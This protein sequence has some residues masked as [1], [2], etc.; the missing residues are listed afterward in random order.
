M[1]GNIIS[2]SASIHEAA[3]QGAKLIA[4]P[5]MTSLM[6]MRKGAL[7]G[8]AVPE[9]DDPAL[10]AFRELAAELKVHL[11]I[12]SLPVRL[13]EQ[14]CANRSFLIAPT[15]A[16]A[17]RYD[18]IHMF[19]VA[20]ND[21][22]DYRESAKFEP[23]REAIVAD[24]GPLSLGLSVCYDLRFPHLYRMLAQAG[25]NVLCVPAAFTR[26]TGQAHW[27][28]LL[29]ARAIENGAYV[30]APAQGGHHADGRETYGH[31]LVVAPWGE[32]IAEL[33]TEPGVLIADLDLALVAEARRKIPALTHDRPIAPARQP[34]L[35]S[36]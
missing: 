17:A 20:V 24:A 3:E 21:G 9:A 2:A 34:A 6:D 31:S 15:G 1:V 13:S 30:L 35:K 26:V 11:L 28:V 22:Q 32:I 14:K 23:G 19:D 18:K 5:E 27:H 29:R 16:V 4:T 7:L 36:P 25:A 12:G 8:K 33:G 10:A